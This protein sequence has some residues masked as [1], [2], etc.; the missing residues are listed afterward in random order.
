MSHCYLELADTEEE[1]QRARFIDCCS[2][3]DHPWNILKMYA[4]H[5]IKG[6][7]CIHTRVVSLY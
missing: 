6:N 3:K 7:S 5:F 2:K 4:R 1:E